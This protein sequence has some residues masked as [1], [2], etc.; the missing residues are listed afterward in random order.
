MTKINLSFFSVPFKLL[1]FTGFLYQ[2]YELSTIY[3]AFKTSTKITLQ[4]D[5]KFVN[6]SIIFC[7]KYT[8]IID[9]TSYKKY[10]IHHKYNYN[11][12]EM[13]DDMSKMTIVET[14][15]HS[16]S[17]TRKTR[18]PL[19]LS[20]PDLKYPDQKYCCLPQIR[21]LLTSGAVLFQR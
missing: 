14:A 11:T 9:R 8:E 1:C 5:N 12:T 4:L 21:S 15:L 2:I 13:F 7:V 6:P 16:L 17:K 20:A 3:F 10:G 19:I 18:M